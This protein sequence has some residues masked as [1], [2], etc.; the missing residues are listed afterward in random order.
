MT[1]PSV[2]T[3]TAEAEPIAAAPLQPKKPKAL[4]GAKTYLNDAHVDLGL[5]KAAQLCWLNIH[6]VTNVS[7]KKQG[8][9]DLYQ[10]NVLSPFGCMYGLQPYTFCDDPFEKF[11]ALIMCGVKH[12][13]LN[14]QPNSAEIRDDDPSSLQTQQA[15]SHKILRGNEHSQGCSQKE[16]SRGQVEGC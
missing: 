7:S 16:D 6:T 8:K 5:K 12:D 2:P 9:I 13:A 11:W 3:A 4:P 1:A 15:L 14:Y 10:A